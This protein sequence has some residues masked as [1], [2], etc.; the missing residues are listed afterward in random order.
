MADTK[1]TLPD[2]NTAGFS[3]LELTVALA[4]VAVV[5]TAVFQLQ[6][7]GFRSYLRTHQMTG[8]VLLAQDILADAQLSPP[9]RG[10]GRFRTSNGEELLWERIVTPTAF[11]GVRDVR[12]LIRIPDSIVPILDVTTYVAIPQ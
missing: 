11:S 6:D 12:V 1:R 2:R 5:A 10:T 9:V 8:A 3:L 7:Q 4:I